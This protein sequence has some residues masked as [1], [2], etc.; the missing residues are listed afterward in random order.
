MLVTS[1]NMSRSKRLDAGH[2]VTSTLLV[3]FGGS[4][5]EYCILK[6]KAVIL[7]D[8]CPSNAIEIVWHTWADKLNSLDPISASSFLFSPPPHSQPPLPFRSLLCP[9][10]QC[11]PGF[12]NDVRWLLRNA[13][14]TAT[15]VNDVFAR[16][17]VLLCQ[18]PAGVWLMWSRW[19][20][21]LRAG[22]RSRDKT[23][24]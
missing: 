22:A 16:I 5:M 12:N 14:T 9:P 6:T 8:V 7:V 24:R 21:L 15:A 3:A 23:T 18:L 2:Q 11:R 20:G 17:T 1:L 19:K 4:L 10:L 13:T